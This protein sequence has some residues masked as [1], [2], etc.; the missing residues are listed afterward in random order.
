[1]AEFAQKTVETDVQVLVTGFP[2]VSYDAF[3]FFWARRMDDQAASDLFVRPPDLF[4]LPRIVPRK[5]RPDS[6]PSPQFDSNN[7][8]LLPQ[9]I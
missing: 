6:C 1:M 5:L 7:T 8:G 3:C 4:F 2:E 9:S